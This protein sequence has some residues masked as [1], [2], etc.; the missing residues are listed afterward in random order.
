MNSVPTLAL[1]VVALLMTGTNPGA[2]EIE[3]LKVAFP[4]PPEFVALTVTVEFPAV[5][6]VPEIKPVVALTFKPA[7]KPDAPNEVGLLLAAIW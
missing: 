1:A 5:V 4:I 2:G 6:G 7:G 3:I